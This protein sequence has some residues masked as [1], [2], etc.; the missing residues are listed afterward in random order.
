MSVYLESS[1]RPVSPEYSR[2][3][4]IQS[5]DSYDAISQE[6]IPS[7]Y[8]QESLTQSIYESYNALN[9]VKYLQ[10]ELAGLSDKERAYYLRENMLSYMEEFAGEIRIKKLKGIVT[11]DGKMNILGS[12]IAEM[13]RKTAQMKGSGSREAM[14]GEGIEKIIQG[15]LEGNNRAVWV[16]P[17]KVAGYGF[18]L[19]FLVDDYDPALQG[20]PFRELLLRYPEAMKTID[21]SRTVYRQLSDRVGIHTPD[22][23][24]FKDYA[25]FL[26]NP[27]R[28]RYDQGYEDLDSL[29]EFLDISP[30]DIKHS[31]EF[32]KEILPEVQPYLDE[33]LILIEEMSR[34][35]SS[36]QTAVFKQKEH[37]ANLLIGAM[38]NISRIVQRKMLAKEADGEARERDDR[39]LQRYKAIADDREA[40]YYNALQMN[41]YEDLV[42]KGGSNCPVAQSG[43]ASTEYAFLQSVQSGLS[44]QDS[45]QALGLENTEGKG[46]VCVTCPYC[47][48]EKDNKLVKG[49]YICGNNRCKSNKKN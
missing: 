27:L 45:M 22:S 35:D 4:I 39:Q 38:F 23:A 36:K 2:D 29:Y 20:R 40:L 9:E 6:R 7:F 28:Y 17:P 26:A 24:H 47:K 48:N 5:A 33:Y 42:I 18:A 13:C 19:T 11:N 8:G 10:N 15:I 31:E 37:D 43:G 16:S 44:V 46:D 21:T 3:P 14:E 41:N 32:R 1:I 34:M 12:D 30:A 25:D 49:R